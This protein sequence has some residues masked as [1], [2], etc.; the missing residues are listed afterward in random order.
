MLKRIFSNTPVQ[1]FSIL[2]AVFLFLDYI[3]YSQYLIRAFQYFEYANLVVTVIVLISVVILLLSKSKKRSFEPEIRN[4]RGMYHY[5]FVLLLMSLTVLFYLSKTGIGSSP[6]AGAFTFLFRT[7]AF[8]FEFGLILLSAI[9]IGSY[10]LDRLKV[11]PEKISG[12][13]IGSAIG[14]FVI[15]IGLFFLGIFGLLSPYIVFPFL[16]LLVIP[17][18]KKILPLLRDLVWKKSEP[19][20][21]HI[22][23]IFSYVFLLLIISINLIS[24]TRSFP[25]G[26]DG[27]NL[28]M[29]IAN[30]IDGYQGLVNGGDAYNWSLLMSLGFIL[31]DNTVVA[32]L[33]SVVP[34]ILSVFVIYRICLYLNINRNWSLLTCTLYYSLPVTIWM[35]R[36][37]EKTDLA[38]L[39][40]SLCAILLLL[41]KN[42]FSGT[43]KKLSGRISK[44]FNFSPDTIVWALCGCL[45]GFSFGI[46]YLAMLNIFA[47]LVL[48][49]YTKAG[50]FAAIA[51]FFLNF[52][53]I[54]ALD[55]TRFAA[56]NSD[57]R[58]E[59]FVVPFVLGLIALAVAFYKNRAGLIIAMKRSFIFLFVIGLTF[60]PWAIK[61]ISEHN[62]ISVDCMLTGKSPLPSLYPEANVTSQGEEIRSNGSLLAERKLDKSLSLAGIDLS[63]I[64]ETPRELIAQ[65]TQ[66]PSQKNDNSQ[67][68]TNQKTFTNK[69]KEEEIRRHL[70]YETGIVRFISLAYD[71]VMKINV[72]VV[73]S[74]MGI[75]MLI[76]LPI[77]MF[78]TSLRHLGW[79]LLKMLFILLILLVSIHSVNVMNGP[80]DYIVVLNSIQGTSFSELATFKDLFL[81]LYAF[82]KIGL[83]NLEK[84]VIPFYN[85]LT[86]QSLGICFILISMFSIPVYFLYRSSLAGLSVLSKSLV[87]FIYCVIQYWLVLSSG[88]LWYGIVG[89]SLVPVIIS[90]M[91]TNEI[92]G[93]YNNKFIQRY[94][95]VC[96]MIWLILILP[97]QFLPTEFRNTKDVSKIR[98]KEFV[99]PNFVSYGAGIKNE[100]EVFN[101]FFNPK[102]KS[103]LNTLNRDKKARVLNISTFLG[104]F[105]DNNDIRVYKDNQLGIFADLFNIAQMDKKLLVTEFRKTKIKYILVSLRTADIDITPDKSLTKKFTDLMNALVNNPEVQ[106]LHTDRL[107][108]RPDGDISVTV[109]GKKIRAKYDVLGYSVVRPG[110]D[111]LFE[112][113]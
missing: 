78:V 104:Y 107:M 77:L 65:A 34:G 22:L 36:N 68:S 74:D 72:S 109:Q 26:Y 55:L 112:I 93:S 110:T 9:C 105:I 62:K 32:I 39:Y 99:D 85:T 49:F 12:V 56:F 13:L 11:V 90:L 63:G 54:Y 111:A 1:L 33:I 103:I 2:W 89:F 40:I 6:V 47:V 75:L 43:T 17:Y 15:T 3:N 69:E 30:L 79:N 59:R 100:K 70:G 5:L 84:A 35:S 81:P 102:Q 29:N 80:F 23:S 57:L 44:Y 4:F 83:L 14:F 106:L 97:L 41:A 73:A 58:L 50:K 94:V 67:L 52:A 48:L 64:M 88:I 7:I 46:K 86:T 82:I 98:L 53:L 91:A 61:H 101:A 10:I 60:L 31:Y 16:V 95:G 45:L 8:H 18:R 51:M 27:L 25:I 24:S 87:L 38:L 71:S 96:L 28:Y 20:K 66:N 92:S 108:E 21:V 19:F 37:D 76:L 42:T 113:L